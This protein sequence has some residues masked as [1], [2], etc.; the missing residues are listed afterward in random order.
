MAD[1]TRAL[2]RES[3]RTYFDDLYHEMGTRQARVEIDGTDLGA[4]TQAEGMVLVGIS[5]D[6]RDDVLVIGL[7]PGG[8][9]ESIEHLV[10][11]P[12]RIVVDADEG[13]IPSAIEAEDAEGHRTLVELGPLVELPAE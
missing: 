5:Y 10:S 7:S 12:Q 6:D 2:A 1:N 13:V 8:P 4:Q 9:D 3:W 11:S